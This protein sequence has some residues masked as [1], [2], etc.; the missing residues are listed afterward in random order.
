MIKTKVQKKKRN[1]AEP[2]EPSDQE[3]ESLLFENPLIIPP[4]LGRSLLDFEAHYHVT[5]KEPI[6]ILG[7]T[8][9]GKSLFLNLSKIYF[10]EECKKKKAV[11]PIVEANCAHFAGGASDLNVT[12]SEL[13]GHSKGAFTGAAGEKIGLVEVADGGLLILE[14]LGELPLE[15]QAMLLTFIETGMSS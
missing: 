13:F 4:G 11:R 14:E 7:A 15:V 10:K 8:G 9:V 3:N 6:L 12:R 1:G 2:L 5:G